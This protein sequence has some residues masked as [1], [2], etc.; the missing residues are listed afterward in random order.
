MGGWV[1]GY[2]GCPGR[3]GCAWLDGKR[4]EEG[5]QLFVYCVFAG[6]GGSYYIR[7]GY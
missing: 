5:R 2:A 6:Y 4:V 7:T 3:Q 1:E